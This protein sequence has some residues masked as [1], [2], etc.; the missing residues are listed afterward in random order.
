MR[1]R[2]AATLRLT[3]TLLSVGI[4]GVACVSPPRAVG[5]TTLSGPLPTPREGSVALA[6]RAP[7]ATDGPLRILAPR[8]TW[9]HASTTEATYAWNCT[10]E[11]PA[12]EGFRVTV[13]VHV[14]DE[15]GRRLEATNQSFQIAARSS[16]PVTGDG[17]IEA[18]A[19]DAVASWRIE[20]WVE[21]N[22]RPIR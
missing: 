21:T 5:P 7:D 9:T 6:E 19:S 18:E 20:Y 8:F 17:L 14:L 3:L 12:D 15:G 2:H 22:P 11:N 1:I 4:L 16:V 10:V 13:V